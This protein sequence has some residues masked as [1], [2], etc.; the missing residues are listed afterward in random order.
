MACFMKAASSIEL[1]VK[2]VGLKASSALFFLKR[3]LSSC[4]SFADPVSRR[5]VSERGSVQKSR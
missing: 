1:N 2:I 5:A 4:L 3:K